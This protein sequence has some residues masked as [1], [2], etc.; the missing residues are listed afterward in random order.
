MCHTNSIQ[1]NMN[2][3]FVHPKYT[4]LQSMAIRFVY[5]YMYMNAIKCGLLVHRSAAEFA[6]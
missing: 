3:F 1:H 5:I 2:G 4:S 6:V